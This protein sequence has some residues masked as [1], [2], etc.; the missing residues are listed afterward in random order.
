M[1][2]VAPQIAPVSK[3]PDALHIHEADDSRARAKV[4][5]DKKWES[6]D[7]VDGDDA[8]NSFRTRSQVA[9]GNAL[10]GEVALRDTRIS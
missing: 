3:I 6:I 7:F 9:L 1:L 10:A 4:L 5:I 8:R 2:P